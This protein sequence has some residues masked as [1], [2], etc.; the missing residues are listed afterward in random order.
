MERKPFVAL[1]Q[2]T[3]ITTS[4]SCSLAEKR[5]ETENRTFNKLYKQT[6]EH[7]TDNSCTIFE[8]MVIFISYAWMYMLIIIFTEVIKSVY[9]KIQCFFLFLVILTTVW[10]FCYQIF[11]FF[12]KQIFK[13]DFFFNILII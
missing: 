10:C 12:L 13:H 4:L 1:K 8:L 2:N 5:C 3:L 11:F 9:E 6:N 7:K